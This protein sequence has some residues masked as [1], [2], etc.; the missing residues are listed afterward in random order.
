MAGEAGQ[1]HRDGAAGALPWGM[2]PGSAFPELG[3]HGQVRTGPQP[4]VLGAMLEC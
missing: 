2:Q 4:P 1:S 3:S